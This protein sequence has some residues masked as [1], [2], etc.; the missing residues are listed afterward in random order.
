MTEPHFDTN[1]E[2]DRQ[3]QTLLEKGYPA[4][5][6]VREETFIEQVAGLRATALTRSAPLAAPPRRACRS[7]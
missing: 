4:L 3:L 7:C 5:A 6:G 2:F 1:A